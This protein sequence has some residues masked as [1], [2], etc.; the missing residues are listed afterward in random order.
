MLV[1]WTKPATDVY[2]RSRIVFWV[3]S[4]PQDLKVSA[5]HVFGRNLDQSD[6]SLG[7]NGPIWQLDLAMR[8]SQPTAIL[9]HV[10]DQCKLSVRWHG[11]TVPDLHFSR[12][13]ETIRM[14]NH[15]CP[16][17][18]LVQHGSDNPTMHNAR[19][20]LVLA[21]DYI[22][23]PYLVDSVVGKAQLESDRA[24]H[25]ANKTMSRVWLWQKLTLVI[26]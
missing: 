26:I 21:C 17:R 9:D 18:S 22:R 8:L 1:Q 7:S 3:Y 10:A 5:I 13:E 2:L 4:P 23:G 6:V 25:S 12:H 11:L 19:V 24:F 16:P 20:P 14:A 15:N